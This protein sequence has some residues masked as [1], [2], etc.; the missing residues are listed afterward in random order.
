M[1][2]GEAEEVLQGWLRGQIPSL[3][4]WT[5]ME[6]SG[7][8][9]QQVLERRS[10]GPAPTPPQPHPD[11][12]WLL[13]VGGNSGSTSDFGWSDVEKALWELDQEA[14]SFLILEQ[15][16]P[17]VPDTCWF[18]QCAVAR[19]GPDQGSYAVEIGCAAPEGSRLWTQIV[20]DMQAAIDDFYDAY[21]RGSLDVSGF[22]ETVL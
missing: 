9:W 11:W 17:Q 13:T 6:R 1:P 16:D 19:Q 4:N 8:T 20:P 14:D 3:E 22:R 2:S 21:D 18:I 10:R 5:K 7:S 15:K 12:P